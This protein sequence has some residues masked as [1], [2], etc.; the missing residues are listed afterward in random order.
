M[1]NWEEIYFYLFCKLT[2]FMRW[3]DLPED[4]WIWLDKNMFEGA[5]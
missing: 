5:L 4:Y 3:M 2:E 1:W